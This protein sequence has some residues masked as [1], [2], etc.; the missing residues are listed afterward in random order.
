MYNS[1]YIS[2]RMTLYHSN[3]CWL[4]C[5]CLGDIWSFQHV[6]AFCVQVWVVG[7]WPKFLPLTHP[8]C[9]FLLNSPFMGLA[10]GHYTP[11][12]GSAVC[13]HYFTF[14][15]TYIFYIICLVTYAG[16]HSGGC[17]VQIPK[18]KTEGVALRS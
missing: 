12:L 1:Y 4:S 10:F 15:W 14:T 17:S 8:I 18:V 3:M 7:N 16:F 6:L 13:K 2:C 11:N 9:E 5:C